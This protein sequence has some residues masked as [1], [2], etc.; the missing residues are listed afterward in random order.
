MVSREGA[1]KVMTSLREVDE[2]RDSVEM[3]FNGRNTTNWRGSK[4]K[5][6]RAFVLKPATCVL[7]GTVP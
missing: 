4:L 6:T 5:R 3:F 1:V 7:D 2:R